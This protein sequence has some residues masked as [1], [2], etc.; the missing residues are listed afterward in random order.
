MVSPFMFASPYSLELSADER[1]ELE[2]LSR[3]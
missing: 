3:S 2:T 1:V